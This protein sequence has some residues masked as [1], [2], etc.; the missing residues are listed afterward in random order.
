MAASCSGG[1]TQLLLRTRRPTVLSRAALH[2]RDTCIC[3]ASRKKDSE[4]VPEGL[5]Q[6]QI[7]AVRR[8]VPVLVRTRLFPRLLNECFA[9]V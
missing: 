9:E 1:L 8:Q 3:G 5:F 4:P 2:K 6:K 7:N